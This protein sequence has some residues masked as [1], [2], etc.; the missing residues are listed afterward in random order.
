MK[1]FIMAFLAIGLCF[2]PNFLIAQTINGTISGKVADANGRPVEGATVY[3]MRLKD[4]VTVKYKLTLKDGSFNIGINSAGTFCIK[5]TSIGLMPYQSGGITVDAQHLLI[6]LNQITMQTSAQILKEV[7][8]TSRKAFLE[9]K[10]DRTVVNVD[11]L[12][13]NA[14]TTA[15]DVLE[16]SPGVAI[17]QVGQISFHGKSGVTIY[18]DDKPTYLSGSDLE[19]Y[20]RSMPSSTLSQIE[21]MTNPPAKYDAAGTAGII[22]IKTKKTKVKG[23]NLGLSLGLRQSR[24]TAVTRR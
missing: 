3:L 1:I 22:N 10:I 2:T 9:Q 14:G 5:V 21:L 16:K 24:Y 18:I 8:V 19:N 20:L 7:I 12:I 23:F 15:L 6:S 4:S 11:A 13:S 17:D